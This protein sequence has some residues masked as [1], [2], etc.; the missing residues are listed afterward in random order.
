MK[1]LIIIMSAAAM[2]AGCQ[3]RITAEKFAETAVPVVENGTTNGVAVLSGGWYVTARSPLWATESIKGLDVGTDKNG[4]VHLRTAEYSRD[5]SSNAV[6]MA[7]NL[8]TDFAVLGEK[9]MAAYGSCGATLATSGA[10]AAVQK[11]M[12]SYILKGGKADAAKVA[13]E[14]GNC[15]FTDGVVTETCLDCVA[16]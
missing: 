11:A 13:C 5:L 12:A 15:T 14:D 10:K 7:H 3:T 8:V 1:K 2:F 16:K 4:A 9:V 6:T